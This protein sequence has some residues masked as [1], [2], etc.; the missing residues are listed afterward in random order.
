MIDEGPSALPV[1]PSLAQQLDATQPRPGVYLLKDQHSK[2]IYVGK[3]KS[4]RSRLGNYFQ[5]WRNIPPRTRAMLEAA[6][7][8]EWIVVDTEVEAL[9][10][11]YTLI[12]RHRPPRL[13]LIRPDTIAR[14]QTRL[15]RRV[16]AGRNRTQ[17]ALACHVIDHAAHHFRRCLQL[18]RHL[19]DRD[20]SP[21]P[22]HSQ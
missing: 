2:V 15:A 9:H 1:A 3:A 14:K 18:T 12:Q 21:S 17:P 6:R 4:L 7:S 5:G 8:V 13:R 11:E 16:A 20:C 19:I 10:L 22:Q